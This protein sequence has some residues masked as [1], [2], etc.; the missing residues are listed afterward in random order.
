MVF[1]QLVNKRPFYYSNFSH[2]EPVYDNNGFRTGEYTEQYSDK[3]LYN[4][5]I[6]Q[7]SSEISLEYFGSKVACEYIILLPVKFP[8]NDNTVF[9][10]DELNSGIPDYKIKKKTKT[11]KYM[12]VAVSRFKS[13]S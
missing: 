3:V 6:L 10:I 2:K 12:F 8:I 1:M 13:G 9:W 11:I 7:A 4:A 5:N